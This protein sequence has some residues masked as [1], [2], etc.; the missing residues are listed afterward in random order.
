MPMSRSDSG[1]VSRSLAA[2]PGSPYWEW[3]GSRSSRSS[4]G[5]VP[6]RHVFAFVQR[7]TLSLGRVGWQHTPAA[8]LPTNGGLGLGEE[9]HG[10]GW[11]QGDTIF[12]VFS[13]HKSRA[14][15]VI[16]DVEVVQTASETSWADVAASLAPGLLRLAWMLTGSMD[17]AEDLLQTTFARAQRHGTRIASMAAPGAYLRRILFNEHL[18][19][20]RRKQVAT[21]PISSADSVPIP[22]PDLDSHDLWP[23][24]TS[25]PR[26]QRAVLVLRYYEDLPDDQIADLVR[27]SRATV[28]SH[29]SQGLATLRTLLNSQETR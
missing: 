13:L 8:F 11:L 20:R 28:R 14:T 21:V 1:V 15:R 24:L 22:A 10:A 18:S 7:S 9:P 29:A 23:W 19:Q 25:L 17:D 27:C 6:R 3:K 26:Q 5:Q 4:S 16:G 2:A 12:L